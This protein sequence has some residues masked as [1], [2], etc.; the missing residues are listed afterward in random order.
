M[1]ENVVDA[2]NL[3]KVFTMGDVKVHALRGLSLQIAPGEVVSIWDRLVLA[4]PP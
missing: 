2:R 1:S 4:N 3:T